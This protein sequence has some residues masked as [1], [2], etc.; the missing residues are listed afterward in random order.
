M[1]QQWGLGLGAGAYRAC[2][3]HSDDTAFLEPA[4][5]IRHGGTDSIERGAIGL[6][7]PGKAEDD[8][9]SI[10]MLSAT[11]LEKLLELLGRA[12]RSCLTDRLY[13]DRTVAR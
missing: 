1:K 5:L 9:Q 12:T 11:L 3:V 10:R 8:G 4:R 2:P 7:I 13:G 6:V